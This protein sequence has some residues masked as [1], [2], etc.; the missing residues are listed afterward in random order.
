M[1]RRAAGLGISHRDG[2]RSW[3]G[4]AQERPRPLDRAGWGSS[5][6]SGPRLWALLAVIAWVLGAEHPDTLAVRADIAHWTR[7]SRGRSGHGREHPD[8]Q[9]VRS[10]TPRKTR[11]E[12][13]PK[14]AVAQYDKLLPVLERIL[15]PKHPNTLDACRDFA[16]STGEAKETVVA[17]DQFAALLPAVRKVLGPEDPLTL[18]V[19]AGLAR[20]TGSKVAWMI[21]PGRAISSPPCCPCTSGF[22]APGTRRRCTYDIA[23]PGGQA[24]RGTRPGLETCTRH[25]CP[26]ESRY[27]ALTTRTPGL[28]EEILTTGSRRRIPKRTSRHMSC[29]PL[30]Q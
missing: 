26:S 23:S 6:S 5:R 17:R 27:L 2:G 9:A 10:D 25:C 20:W 21:R 15:G 16:W 28:P 7:K 11:N 19:R 3:M 13:C 18:D 1:S 14:R 8:T 4:V 24:K 12:Q 30:G 29:M 22:W